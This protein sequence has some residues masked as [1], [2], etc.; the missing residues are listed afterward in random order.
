[1]L[2]IITETIETLN[3]SCLNKQRFVHDKLYER[4]NNKLPPELFVDMI[5]EP[6]VTCD[7][8]GDFD[9]FELADDYDIGY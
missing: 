9:D 1:M 5:V 6:E 3:G 4:I 8:C 2:H 7:D